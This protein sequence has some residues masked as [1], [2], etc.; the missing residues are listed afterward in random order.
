MNTNTIKNQFARMGARFEVVHQENARRGADYA[1]DL[2]VDRRGQY[3]ELRV[4]II[5]APALELTVQVQPRHRH[6]VLLVKKP[7]TKDRFLCGHDER[8]WF[9]A[10]VPGVATTVAQAQQALKPEAIRLAETRG[11]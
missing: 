10:A 1:L 7:Q 6:L 9:V 4:P 11:A 2:S 5:V 8:E 3:F